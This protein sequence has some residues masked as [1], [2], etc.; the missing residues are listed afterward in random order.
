MYTSFLHTLYLILHVEWNLN[1]KP[2]SSGTRI[3]PTVDF[4]IVTLDVKDTVSSDAGILTCV[5]TNKFGTASTTGTLKV[6]EEDSIISATQHPAGKSGLENIDK[7]ESNVAMK[8][9]SKA[10]EIPVAANVKPFFTMGLPKEVIIEENESLNLQCTVEPKN[11]S[12]LELIWYHNG[13]PLSSGSRIEAS[14]DFGVVTLNI[15][16]MSERD[17]GI[18]TCKA[19]NKIGEAVVF[20]TVNSSGKSELDLSTKHPK[21]IEGFKAIAEFEAKGKLEGKPE[22]PDQGQAPSFVTPF[23]DASVAEG[24]SVYFE[25]QLLPKG[26]STMNI[27]WLKDDK[28]VQESKCDII[29]TVHI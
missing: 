6:K 1:D 24:D 18:Y 9:E 11:D 29:P 17:Q 7:T 14:K 13:I 26:D 25:T 8:L 16:N 12:N 3:I 20:T 10:E 4:G 22:E 27:E 5:A 19:T 2:L 23:K 15:A 21:G 28:P